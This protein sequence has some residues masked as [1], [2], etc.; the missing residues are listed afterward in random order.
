M[1]NSPGKELRMKKW[2]DYL[3]ATL[4]LILVVVTTMLITSGDTYN[5]ENGFIASRAVKVTFDKS[6]IVYIDDGDDD[7]SF[8]I[9]SPVYYE[10][11][12]DTFLVPKGN[13]VAAEGKILIDFGEWLKNR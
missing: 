11:I 10:L 7:L 9:Q 8:V 4:I 1:G 3:I 6:N 2:K 13:Q 12:T 5:V